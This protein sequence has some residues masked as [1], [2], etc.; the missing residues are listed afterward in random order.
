MK[1]S[2]EQED[3]KFPPPRSGRNIQAET[4]GDWGPAEPPHPASRAALAQRLQQETAARELAEALHAKKAAQLEE[5]TKRIGR[6]EAL[7]VG[8]H[9]S[10]GEE[11]DG[12]CILLDE[13]AQKIHG[14]SGG[15]CPG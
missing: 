4:L 3:R 7:I 9:L 5:A 14:C 10:R 1:A 12:A 15:V 2:A 11:L 8:V 13:E 6:L